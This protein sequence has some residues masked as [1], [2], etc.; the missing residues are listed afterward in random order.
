MAHTLQFHLLRT[1]TACVAHSPKPYHLKDYIKSGVKL[2]F[3]AGRMLI[4]NRPRH[5]MDGLQ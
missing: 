3:E 2:A 1:T 5:I 4:R